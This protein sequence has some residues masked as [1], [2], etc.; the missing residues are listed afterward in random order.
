MS[1]ASAAVQPRVVPL[2]PAD[3]KTWVN[4]P[5]P[6]DLTEIQAELTRVGGVNPHGEPNF[7]IVWAQEYRTWECGAMRIHFDDENIPAIHHPNRYACRMDV[8]TRATDWFD[9]QNKLRQQAYMAMDWKA[10]AAHPDMGEY[11]RNHEDQSGWMKLPHDAEDLGRVA[12]MLPEG[13]MYVNG[14][15]TFEHI[16]QQCYYILQWFRE[17]EYNCEK[18]WND[19]RFDKVYYPETDREEP[20]IDVLGPYPGAGQYE[21]PIIRIGKVGSFKE[22]HEVW[23]GDT[24]TREIWRYVQPTFQNTVEPLQEL[25]RIREQATKQDIDPNFRNQQRFKDFQESRPVR[26]ERHRKAFSE[27]FNDAKP[28]GKGNPTNISANKTKFDN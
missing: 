17:Q 22:R 15:H 9:K 26:K 3:P 2:G 28:V 5:A 12:R 27:K 18:D 13:W 21:K 7:K 20:F 6:D 11:L 10:L 23:V 19:L 4:T 25:L 14:H 16:G 8:F 24:I 1:I